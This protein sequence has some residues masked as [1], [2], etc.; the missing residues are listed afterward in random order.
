M[1][2]TID[3]AKPAVR[4]AV[5]GNAGSFIAFRVGGP[6]GEALEQIFASDMHRVH[7]QNL[8]KHE[9]IA[10]IQDQGAPPAPFRGVTLAPIEYAG[11]R[12]DAIITLSRE[13]FARPREIVEP[14]IH[15]LFAAAEAGKSPP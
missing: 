10:N 6:D 5:L 1:T 8:K 12:K 11:G 13:K 15:T 7:F 9:V 3:Q 2:G 4:Q 14:R